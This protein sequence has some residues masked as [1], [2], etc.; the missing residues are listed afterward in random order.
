MQCHTSLEFLDKFSTNNFA[1]LY[2]K[3]NVSEQLNRG[4][5]VAL[6]LL[7]TPLAVCQK[8]RE[9]SFW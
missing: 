3:D 8:S 4:G 1:L 7:R 5:I 6:P 9:P 2:P